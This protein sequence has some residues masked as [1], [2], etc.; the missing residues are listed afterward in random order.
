VTNEFINGMPRRELTPQER[1]LPY[2]RYYFKDMARIPDGDLRAVNRGPVDPSQA[3]D[4]RDSPD[5]YVQMN[6]PAI[7]S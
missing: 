2:A 6:G 4:I 1:E 5:L 3:L 7:V